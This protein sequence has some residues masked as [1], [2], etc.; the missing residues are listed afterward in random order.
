MGRGGKHDRK[1]AKAEGKEKATKKGSGIPKYAFLS[2]ASLAPYCD[3]EGNA[4]WVGVK[5]SVAELLAPA[6]I[7]DKST[8]KNSEML[9]RPGMALSLAAA[10]LHHGGKVVVK[11]GAKKAIEELATR[12]DSPEAAAFLEAAKVLNLGKSGTQSR[13]TV[14]KAVRRH[15]KFLQSGDEKLQKALV[16]AA[17]SAAKVYLFA[18]HALEQKAFLG[19]ATTWAKKWQGSGY[20]PREMKDWLKDSSNTE[21]LEKLV[22]LVMEKIAKHKKA[23][24]DVS[25]SS[26]Q[27]ADSS[28]SGGGKKVSSASSTADKHKKSKKADKKKEKKKSRKSKKSEAASAS[29]K[30]KK[31]QDR[32]LEIKQSS[33]QA[34]FGNRTGYYPGFNSK[35]KPGSIQVLFANKAGL[36]LALEIE[37]GYIIRK[38]GLSG[39]YPG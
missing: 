2:K 22:D 29:Q 27:A 17:A 24:K 25:S 19:K 14:E 30:E 33:I 18:M 1:P 10:A 34:P 37:P 35:I 39:L 21:K 16:E 23:A 26:R 6:S 9:T 36:I 32:A 12:L 15:V 28:S 5:D 38:L 11:G 13:A 31:K 4:L 20:P 8:A 3:E 7:L